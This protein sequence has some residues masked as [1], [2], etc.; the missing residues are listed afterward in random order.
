[1]NE[2]IIAPISWLNEAE[3]L[4]GV[5]PFYRTSVHDKPFESKMYRD[6]AERSAA[7]N[8]DVLDMRKGRGSRLGCGAEPGRN[9]MTTTWALMTS[10]ARSNREA[11]VSSRS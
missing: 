3:A 6:V 5:E 2:H 8:I 10:I 4:L 1:V 11:N 9:S 7:Q